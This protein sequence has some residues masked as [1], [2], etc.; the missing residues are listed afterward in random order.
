MPSKSNFNL[1]TMKFKKTIKLLAAAVLCVALFTQ[2]SD[3]DAPH[4]GE[5]AFEDAIDVVE[6]EEVTD[7]AMASLSDLR[8]F[9]FEGNYNGV[10]KAI[11]SR[12]S[13]KVTECNNDAQVI[14]FDGAKAASLT[15]DESDAIMKAYLNN[16][17]IVILNPAE[18]QWDA[19]SVSMRNASILLDKSGYSDDDNFE[20]AYTVISHLFSEKKMLG[21]TYDHEKESENTPFNAIGLCGLNV[22]HMDK[23][24]PEDLSLKFEYNDEDGKTANGTYLPTEML[25]SEYEMGLQADMMINWVNKTVAGLEEDLMEREE[26]AQVLTR[27]ADSPSLQDITSGQSHTFTGYFQV[28]P[29][30]GCPFTVERRV[31]SLYSPSED[32]DYFLVNQKIIMFASKLECGPDNSKKEWHH[33]A[34]N[35]WKKWYAASYRHYYFYGPYLYKIKTANSFVETV[36]G[37]SFKYAKIPGVE[38]LD[39]SPQNSKGDVQEPVSLDLSINAAKAINVLKPG[40]K[41]SDILGIVNVKMKGSWGVTVEKFGIDVVAAD[42]S[43]VWTF[44]S[45]KVSYGYYP[46]LL[47]MDINHGIAATSQKSDQIYSQSWVMRVKNPTRKSYMLNQ[48]LELTGNFI[49]HDTEI[50]TFIFESQPAYT[51]QAFYGSNTLKFG[52]SAEVIAPPRATQE[53]EIYG[54]ILENNSEYGNT[55]FNRFLEEDMLRRF[56]SYGYGD[57]IIDTNTKEDRSKVDYCWDEFIAALDNNISYFRAKH[58]YGKYKFYLKKKNAANVYKIHNFEVTKR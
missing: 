50:F 7:D 18:A 1:N 35:Y 17:A 11:V 9:V 41:P 25:Q 48:E 51:S 19:F 52:H 54:E 55:E 58:M 6:Y 43:A 34:S 36:D 26:A 27:A 16:A 53:W 32:A 39:W 33:I 56:G 45:P 42:G 13:N 49:T 46:T 8:A 24:L 15:A 3:D 38:V 21:D 22:I 37:Q 20:H 30:R 23:V 31:W 44:T 14:V 4:S 40:P 28:Y 57:L 10:P 12:F 5:V 29:G 2:C 47:G